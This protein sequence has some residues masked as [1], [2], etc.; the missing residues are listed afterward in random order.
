MK[1]LIVYDSISPMKLTAKVAETIAEGLKEKGFEVDSF[2]VKD[3][4]KTT[5]IA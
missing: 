4:D 5:T 2:Y 1:V 3:V